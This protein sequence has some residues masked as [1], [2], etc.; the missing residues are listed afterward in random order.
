[1]TKSLLTRALHGL[2]ALAVVHQLLVSLVMEGPRHGHDAAGLPG[3]LFDLHEGVGLFT[4]GVVLA[5][6]LWAFVRRSGTPVAMLFPWLSGQRLRAVKEDIAR[7]AE[8]MRRFDLPDYRSESPLAAAT[9]G[10]GLLVFTAMGATGTVIYFTHGVPGTL[11]QVAK[12]SQEVHETIANLAWA[13]LIGHAGIA[14]LHGLKGH[15]VMRPMFRVQ[16]RHGGERGVPGDTSNSA[17]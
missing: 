11:G 7:H 4:F 3:A 8:A 10:L 12:V 2:L 17:S 15:D 6:W 5:F 1:M 13:Y 16:A 14:L 9:H